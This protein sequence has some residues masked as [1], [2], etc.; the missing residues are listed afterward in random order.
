MTSLLGMTEA[1]RRLYRAGFDYEARRQA[2][3]EA[4]KRKVEAE[5]RLRSALAA[6][7]ATQQLEALARKLAETGPDDLTVYKPRSIIAAVALKHGLFPADLTGSCKSA[8]YVRARQEAIWSVRQ[9]TKLST[10]Q[11]GQIFGRDHTT[12]LYSIKAYQAILESGEPV[13]SVNETV[14]LIITAIAESGLTGMT[15]EE[16]GRA[17]LGGPILTADD[18]KTIKSALDRV[19]VVLPQFNR[20]LVSSIPGHPWTRY[21]IADGRTSEIIEA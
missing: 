3:A 12:I 9:A 6:R 18:R 5:A 16:I 20:R 17:V 2:E 21:R 19:R 11:I 15:T 13:V 14:S 10:P 4:A 7:R 8:R 1:R